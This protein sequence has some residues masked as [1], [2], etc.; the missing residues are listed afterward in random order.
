MVGAG[1]RTDRAGEPTIA[2]AAS[3]RRVVPRLAEA[4]SRQPRGRKV[5]AAYG[6]SGDLR[7]RLEDGAPF[8]AVM[9]A[10]ATPV[11]ALIASG[12]V[13][14]ASRRVVATNDLVLI[15]PAARPSKLTF[16]TIDQLPRGERIAI[17]E[18]GAVPAGQYARQA[19]ERLGKWSALEGR[20]VLAGDVGAVLAYAR[21]GEVAA[22]VVY[23]TE[24][25]GVDDV[26]VLD[27]ARGAW[28][29]APEVVVGVV[30]AGRHAEPARAFLE[31]VAGPAGQAILR[32]HGFGAGES[33]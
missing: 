21:R 30:A 14:A 13:E 27:R 8:D 20:V 33:S 11:D 17:G 15:A 6:A 24:L 7:K 2:A 23:G 1:C 18:P 12:H 10:S 3:L 29:P 31:L 16:A 25:A 28:A 9:L 26:V 22:A 32:D 19:F 5:R 4:F